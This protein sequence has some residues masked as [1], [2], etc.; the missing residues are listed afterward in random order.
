MMTLRKLAIGFLTLSL[1]LITLSTIDG[2]IASATVPTGSGTFSWG[3]IGTMSFTPLTN[4][5]QQTVKA[6]VAFS[7]GGAGECTGGTPT[8]VLTKATG[9]AKLKDNS[10]VCGP[11]GLFNF[12]ITLRFHYH[13]LKTSIFKGTI[14]GAGPQGSETIL[15]I[16]GGTVAG[17]Y[18]ST[19]ASFDWYFASRELSNCGS[20]L[21]SIDFQ[22]TLSNFL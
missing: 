1:F 11:M 21:S 18:A 16:G 14:Q 9:T 17:S 5:S 2:G 13:H 19:D 20:G 7:G 6:T 3:P 22:G 10:A 8:A 12:S 15:G 4:N